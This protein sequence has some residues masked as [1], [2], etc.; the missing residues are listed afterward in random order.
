MGKK[1][2]VVFKFYELV[3]ICQ[4]FFLQHEFGSVIVLSTV[5][6]TF[7]NRYISARAELEIVGAYSTDRLRQVVHVCVN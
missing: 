2:T 3:Q 5:D 6:D 1:P 7:T 4:E